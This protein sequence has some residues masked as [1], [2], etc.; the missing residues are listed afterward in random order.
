MPSIPA[1][2]LI[3]GTVD[4][5]VVDLPGGTALVVGMPPSA[6]A[7]Y[8][9]RI[10]G[11]LTVRFALPLLTPA[12]SAVIPGLFASEKGAFLV[13]REA[14]DYIQGNFMMHPRADVVGITPDGSPIQIFL[15]E[16]DLGAPVQVF[17]SDTPDRSGIRLTALLIGDNAPILPDLLSLYLPVQPLDA[18]LNAAPR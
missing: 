12:T 8:M 2:E 16:I 6:L 4:G 1:P 11:S 10:K 17:A 18:L 3:S 5:A 13:G 9:P 7:G 14:W 15:R